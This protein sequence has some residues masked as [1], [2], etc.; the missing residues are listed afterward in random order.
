M[1]GSE[2]RVSYVGGTGN[3]VTLECIAVA[4][5]WLGTFN[6]LWSN[7]N[8]WGGGTP[9]AGD[10]LVFTAGALNKTITNDLPAG[11]SF[12][13]LTFQSPGYTLAGN[14]I[15]V[16]GSIEGAFTSITAPIDVGANTVSISHATLA[17][18]L[19]G[20]GTVVLAEVA[21]DQVGEREVHRG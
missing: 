11:T 12:K 15:V 21:L 14:R 18:G 2:F 5:P 13:S 20:T 19:A 10:K 6:A 4:R 8:N 3:D 1:N 16:T 9:L 7:A 17:G